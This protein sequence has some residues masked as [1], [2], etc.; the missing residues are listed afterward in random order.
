MVNTGNLKS[1]QDTS[2]LSSQHTGDK[3][4]YLPQRDKGQGIRDKNR[5][6]RTRERGKG[7]RERGEKGQGREGTRN[8]HLRIGRR[9]K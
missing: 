8:Y 4:I 1:A 9:Q 3:E 2:R 7:T 6:Q 5:R